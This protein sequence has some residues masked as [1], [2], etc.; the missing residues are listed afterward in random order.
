[1]STKIQPDVRGPHGNAIVRPKRGTIATVDIHDLCL[2]T[3]T[4]T[5]VHFAATAGGLIYVGATLA[6]SFV[7][8]SLLGPYVANDFWWPE[9]NTSGTQTFIADLYNTK[10]A[11]DTRG[12]LDVVG[13]GIWKD[14]SGTAPTTVDVRQNTARQILHAQLPLDVA[15]TTLRQNPL[16]DNIIAFV[17]VCWLDL[18]RTFELAHTGARQRRCDKTMRWNGAVYLESLLRNTAAAD[19]ASST[20]LHA[21]QTTI[22]AAVETTWVDTLLAQQQQW[23]AVR[24]EVDVWTQH[25]LQLWQHQ[26]QNRYLM[27]VDETIRVTSAMGVGQTVTIGSIAFARRSA[28]AWTT[29]YA[30]YGLD[31]DLNGCL[32]T[33]S[34][35]VRSASHAFERVGNDWDRYYNGPAKTIGSQLIR[36]RIGPLESIDVW[37]VP[38]TP[39]LRLFAQ[40]STDQVW[41]QIQSRFVSLGTVTVDAVPPSWWS[42]N[43]S[44]GGNPL[45]PYNGPT[46]YIQP[47][48]DFYDDCGIQIRHTIT[49]TPQTTLFAMLALNMTSNARTVIPTVCG[50]CHT[51]A[52]QCEQYLTQAAA[53]L[54]GTVV[55]PALRQA[56]RNATAQ[57]VRLNISYIQFLTTLPDGT[58]TIWS[59]PMI[60]DPPDWSWTFFGWTAMFDWVDKSR[61]VYTFAG[62]VSNVTLVSSWHGHF[63]MATDPLELPQR[64]CFFVWLSAV[65]A[66]AILVVVGLLMLGYTAT[67]AVDGRNFIFMNRVVGGVWLGRPLLFARGLTAMAIL[68]TCPMSL[69]VVGL[70]RFQVVARPL[71]HTLVLAGEASWVTYALNDCLLPLTQHYSRLYAPL[72]ATASWMAVLVHS[73]LWP[74]DPRFTIGRNCTIVS[75]IRGVQCQSGAVEIGH[76]ANVETLVE[77]CV[78]STVAAYLVVRGMLVLWPTWSPNPNGKHEHLLVP[79]SADVFFARSNRR[80][81]AAA[82]VMAGIL[83]FPHTIFNISLWSTFDTSEALDTRTVASTTI[84]QDRGVAGVRFYPHWAIRARGVVGFVIMVVSVS[85]CYAFLRMT[86]ARL[87]NDFLWANF[88]TLAV[89][90]YVCNWF[91]QNLQVFRSGLVLVVLNNATFGAIAAADATVINVA[92]LYAT[93]VQDEINTIGNV[94]HGLRTMDSCAVPWIATAYCYVDFARTWEMATSAERQRRCT[95]STHNGAVFLEAMLRNVNWQRLMQCWGNAIDATVLNELRTS[96]DGRAW[97]ESTRVNAN[98]VVA[99]SATWRARGIVDFTTQWQNYKRLAVVESF[100]ITSAFGLDYPVALKRSR[101]VFQLTSQTSFKLYWAWANDLACLAGRNSSLVRA[102]PT[103]AFQNTSLEDEGLVAM[104][105]D[106]AFVLFRTTVGPFGSV[107]AYRVPVPKTLLVLYQKITHVILDVASKKQVELRAASSMN[108]VHTF[109][110]QPTAWDGA[111]LWGG[112]LLCP[113]NPGPVTTPLKYFSH[114]GVCGIYLTDKFEASAPLVMKGIVAAGLLFGRPHAAWQRDTYDSTSTAQ[115]FATLTPLLEQTINLAMYNALL[116]SA[117]DAKQVVRRVVQLQLVQYIARPSGASYEPVEL[118]QVDVFD[119]TEVDLEFYAWLYLFEWVEGRREVVRF[120]GDVGAITT[121]STEETLTQLVATATQVPQNVMYYAKVLLQYF[122]AVLVGLASVVC[123]YIVA[124]LGIVEGSNMI[125]FNR[126]AGLVWLGRPLMVLRGVVALALLST[127]SLGVATAGLVA[128]FESLPPSY[129]TTLVSASEMT[130]LVFAI[131]DVASIVAREHTPSFS[132]PCCLVACG[133]TLLLSLTSPVTPRVTIARTCAV[134]S[135]DFDAV[136]HSGEI[137][138]GNAGRFQTL[139]AAAVVSF[140]ACYATTWLL[141]ARLAA[142]PVPASFLLHASANYEFSKRQWQVQGLYFLDPASALLNG[143]VVVPW[144]RHTLYVLDIK[145]WRTFVM[146]NQDV[147]DDDLSTQFSYCIPVVD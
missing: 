12:T 44:F 128:Y 83:S 86:D 144:G 85:S 117:A 20:Y 122:T 134:A 141:R 37:R 58:P 124:N 59:Q 7:Y 102:S 71:W 79:A 13:D 114:L 143:V 4:T 17:A 142:H 57:L 73:L 132:T 76:V 87:Q 61:G 63:A 68:S 135:V 118:S 2:A 139:V 48:F 140:G 50:S 49:L 90:A 108:T 26:M 127:S 113:T 21:I 81:D 96:K 120:R 94:I 38:M 78:A 52:R 103:F 112:D 125:H 111:Q 97:I 14:Y 109:A 31:N 23:L 93:E 9:Y 35:M 5:T 27:G 11:M 92:P 138:I 65:Y 42:F 39:G 30:S 24:D 88:N 119:S 25:G 36:S 56:I 74:A 22:F 64:A 72:S 55:S 28:G 116:A 136:C 32:V 105:W 70:T 84:R 99:E 29:Q 16:S 66:T 95:A 110:P 75:F 80:L 77:L 45:C 43:T 98:T 40:L 15:I 33:N 146:N 91:N 51:S 115:M 89:Q 1:M 101:S 123:L 133:V 147:V 145:S 18:N 19:M 62:D 69:G 121:I 54:E 10:L 3:T 53:L 41:R 46:P 137:A 82:F 107:D 106:V 8:L 129:V 126:I 104:P 131:T 67:H 34:S 130:W 60:Q 47:S 100:S 6:C